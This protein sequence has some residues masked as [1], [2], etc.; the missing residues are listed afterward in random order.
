VFFIHP[1]KG[2]TLRWP[3][4]IRLETN[5]AFVLQHA[6]EFGQLRPAG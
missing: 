4:I 1:P 3:P 2:E 6:I 5:A